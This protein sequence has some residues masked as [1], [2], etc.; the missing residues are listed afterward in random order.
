MEIVVGAVLGAAAATAVVLLVVRRRRAAHELLF[1]TPVPPT[2]LTPPPARP[3]AAP[4]PTPGVADLVGG[5][6]S[7]MDDGELTDDEIRRLLPGAE[8]TRDG[9]DVTVVQRSTSSST[10]IEVDGKVYGSVD[11]IPDPEL[12]EQVRRFLGG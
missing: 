10:R 1:G 7:A 4:G 5:L 11:E 8:V 3:P 6:R 2:L 9:D 12:R